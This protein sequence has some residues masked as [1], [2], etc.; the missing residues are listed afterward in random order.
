M[1]SEVLAGKW[2]IVTEKSSSCIFAEEDHA[3]EPHANCINGNTFNLWSL[4]PVLDRKWG[5]VA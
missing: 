3:P 5:M 2:I 1:T 4:L